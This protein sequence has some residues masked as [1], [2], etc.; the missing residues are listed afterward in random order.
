M[1]VYYL[2]PTEA[3]PNSMRRRF[4]PSQ[5]I[6]TSVAANPAAGILDAFRRVLAQGTTPDVGLLATSLAGTAVLLALGYRLFKSL[7]PGF[8]D[9]V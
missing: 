2:Y 1:S 7:E 5:G 4:F 9:L 3:W 6:A 8:A